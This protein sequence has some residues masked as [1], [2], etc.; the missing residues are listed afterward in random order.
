MIKVLFDDDDEK[1]LKNDMLQVVIDKEI[2]ENELQT[3]KEGDVL[4]AKIR[5][6]TAMAKGRCAIFVCV[7]TR[8]RMT[9]A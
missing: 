2:S 7:F 5:N 8:R 9:E 4:L 1:Y 6:S 3:L